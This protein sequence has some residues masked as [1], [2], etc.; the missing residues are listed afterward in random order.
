MTDKS[1]IPRTEKEAIASGLKKWT[2]KEFA[3]IKKKYHF[4]ALVPPF[5]CTVATVGQKCLELPCLDGY[6][7]VVYCGHNGGCTEAYKSRC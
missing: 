7:T 4:E 6:I 5:H 1:A 2:D 3:E